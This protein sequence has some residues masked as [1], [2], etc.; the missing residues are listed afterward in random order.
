MLPAFTPTCIGTLL[1]GAMARSHAFCCRK[2]VKERFGAVALDGDAA[3][4]DVEEEVL[5]S[6]LLPRGAL[7]STGA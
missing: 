2:A 4:A 7:L 3:A 1:A 6:F 5:A